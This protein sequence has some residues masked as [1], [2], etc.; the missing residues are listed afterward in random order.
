MP[1][2]VALEAGVVLKTGRA[3]SSLDAL[4][5]AWKELRGRLVRDD[6]DEATV[7]RPRDRLV[8]NEARV[9]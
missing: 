6:L 4:C 3:P 5:A 8:R 1:G 9:R 7:L 2:F